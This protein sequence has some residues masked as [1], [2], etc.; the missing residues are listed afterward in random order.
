MRRINAVI[1]SSLNPMAIAVKI[2]F[3]NPYFYI[4][5]IALILVLS[6]ASFLMLFIKINRLKPIELIKSNV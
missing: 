6:V 3:N 1:G 4:A 2:V 5:N